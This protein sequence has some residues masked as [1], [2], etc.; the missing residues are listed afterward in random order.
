M[1][2]TI[3]EAVK[4]AKRS[5]HREEMNRFG[6]EVDWIQDPSIVS[7]EVLGDLADSTN[8]PERFYGLACWTIGQLAG[9]SGVGHSRLSWGE[10]FEK[11]QLSNPD[12]VLVRETFQKHPGIAY[13]PGMLAMSEIFAAVPVVATRDGI[14]RE[15]W[16]TIASKASVFGGQIARDDTDVQYLVRNYLHTQKER[17]TLGINLYVLDVAK[18]KLDEATGIT[19]VTPINDLLGESRKLISKMFTPSIDACVALQAK[20]PCPNERNMFDATWSAFGSISD[21]II[22][23]YVELPTEIPAQA[24]TDTDYKTTLKAGAVMILQEALKTYADLDEVQPA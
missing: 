1:T 20:S 12:R 7:E 15:G 8:L 4:N 19:S 16:G 6:S 21:R 3:Y 2:D 9:W 5:L 24:D 10:T 11:Y 18:L 17:P 14:G 13:A 22:Y 23:P